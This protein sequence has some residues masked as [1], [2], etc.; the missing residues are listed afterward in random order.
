MSM[1][2][3]AGRGRTTPSEGGGGA[4]LFVKDY[5]A[6]AAPGAGFDDGPNIQSP[7]ELT[8]AR[9]AGAGPSGEDI[10]RYTFA[11]QP[12]PSGQFGLG[13][14]SQF[15]GAPFAYGDEAYLRF[16]YRINAGALFDFYDDEGGQ[17]GVGR[18]KFII[19]ND[20]GDGTTSR[21]ILD[22]QMYRDTGSG[23]LTNWRLGI[24]GG[25]NAV[26]TPDAA[27]DSAWHAV[28]MRLRY[29][30]AFGESDGGW[31]IWVDNDVEGSPDATVSGVPLYADGVDNGLVKLGAYLN[32]GLREN[33][34]LV[35]DE[36]RFAIRDAFMPNWV[37][38]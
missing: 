23:Q 38:A 3:M 27:L 31:D 35:L 12:H 19:V 1:L 28:Q 7:D 37:V 36:A 6:G 32:N 18:L 4:D 9:V 20:S 17:S 11:H 22:I 10:T 24:G 13:W 15:E 30:S 5:S 29:S 16:L 2:A 34:V 26:Q 33:G 21:P 8:I 14:G 25:V